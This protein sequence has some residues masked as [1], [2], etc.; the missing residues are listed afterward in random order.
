MKYKKSFKKNVVLIIL[1]L[2]ILIVGICSKLS[3]TSFSAFSVVETIWSGEVAT[4]FSGG[5]GTKDNPYQISRGEELAYFKTV[6]ESDDNSNYLDKYYV[7]TSNINL[8]N[9]Y[10]DPI[11]E[12]GQIFS[13]T[14]DGQGYTISNLKIDLVININNNLY[15]GLFTKTENATI[16]NLNISNFNIEITE[17]SSLNTGLL[18]ASATN[19]NISNIAIL[20]SSIT[21]ITQDNKDNINI[22]GLVGTI[23]NS[24][25]TNLYLNININSNSKYN[26]G[27][28]TSTSKKTSY[29]NILVNS[30]LDFYCTN[31]ITTTTIYNKENITTDFVDTLNNNLTTDFYWI[32]DN[33]DYYLY[34]EEIALYEDEINTIDVSDSI[35]LHDSGIENDIVYVNDLD[36]DYNYYM[37]LN[38]TYSSDNKL[39]TTNNKK[40]YSDNNLVNV[41]ITYNGSSILTGNTTTGT[42]STTE[43]ENKYIYYKVYP[44][45]DNGTSSMTDDYIEI[46][47]IDNPF[48]NRPTDYGF[49][50]WFTDYSGTKISIDSTIYTRYAKVP[51]TYTGSKPNDIVIEFKAR[52]TPAQ[53]EQVLENS[54]SAL[55]TA[56]N[57]FNSYGLQELKPYLEHKTITPIYGD[58]SQVDMTQ[59]YTRITV[60]YNSQYSNNPVTYDSNGNKLTGRC[61]TRN[62]CTAYQKVTKATYNA[63]T[64]YYELT[65]TGMQVL[66]TTKTFLLDYDIDITYEYLFDST[67]NMSTY[68]EQ[69]TITRNNSYAGYYNAAGEY[70]TSGTCTSNNGCTYYKLLQYYDS[71]GKEN[72]YDSTKNYYYLVTRDTNLLILNTNLSQ[73]WGTSQTKPLT[74]TGLYSGVQND[75]T[76]DV[77]NNYVR[78]SA[79]LVIENMTINAG[80]TGAETTPSNSNTS[81]KYFYGGWNNVKIGRGISRF[82]SNNSF[83]VAMG[84]VNSATGSSNNITKYRFI[85][86]SGFYS[87]LSVTGG[88]N[89]INVYINGEAIYGNDYDR[90]KKDNNNLD[91]YFCASGSWGNKVY[92]SGIT[93]IA[94]HTTVKSGKFGSARPTAIPNQNTSNYSY[95]IYVGGRQGGANY[96]AREATIEGGWVYNLIGGPLAQS[97]NAGYNDSYIYVKGGEVDVIIGGAGRTETYGNRIIQVTGGTINYSIFGG[98]NGVTSTTTSNQ[99]GTLTGTPYIYVGGNAIIGNSDYV[100]NN[101]T[102]FGFEAGSVFGIGNGQSGTS[103]IGTADNSYIIIDGSATILRNVYG[104]GN[105]GAVG[106]ESSASTFIT[107]INIYGGTIKGSVFGGGNKNGSGINSSNTSAQVTINQTSGTVEGS[108]YG[109]ANEEGTIY[110]SVLINSLGG[111]I[112]TDIYGGGYGGLTN[113]SNGTYVRDSITIKVGDTTDSILPTIEGSVYGGSAFGSVNGTTNT[114]NTSSNGI[115]ITVNEGVIKTAVF[116]GAKGNSTYTPYVMGNILVTINGG[117]IADVFGGNNAAGTP[118]GTI[119]IYLNGGV[120]GRTFGGGNQASVNT[121]NIYLEGAYSELIFG[122]SN[123]DGTVTTSNI[124]VN[125]GESATIYGGNNTDGETITSN[126]IINGGTINN[127]VYGGGNLATTTTTNILLKASIIPNVYGGGANADIKDSTNVILNGATV[128]NIY[129]GSNAGGSVTQSFITLKNGI[130]QSVYGGNNQDGTTSTTN[131]IAQGGTITNIYGGG[132]Q[133]GVNSSNIVLDNGNIG[134]VYGGSNQ[135]G[136]VPTTNIING[137]STSSS[138]K[139]KLLDMAIVTKQEWDVYPYNSM[140]R[141]TVTITNNT[142]V[143]IVKWSGTIITTDAELLY[144]WSSTEVINN[145]NVYTFNEKNIW[146]SDNVIPSGGSYTFD[147]LTGNFTNYSEFEVLG[148][149]IVG[150]DANGNEYQIYAANSLNVKN[151]YGGNNLGGSTTTPY[152]NLTKGSYENVYGGGNQAVTTGSTTVNV[153]DIVVKESLYG[154]GNQAAVLGNTIVNVSGTTSITK[155]VFGGGNHGAVGDVSSDDSTAIVNIVGSTIGGNVYGGCNTSVVYGTTQVNIGLNAVTDSSM[156]KDN[157]NISGTIF[158]GGEANE[159]GSESYDFSFIS[160]TQGIDI[161]IDGTG[162]ADNNLDFIMSGSIFGSGNASSSSGPSN[163]YIRKLGTREAPNTSISIQRADQ[164]TIDSSAIELTGTTDRTNE[165]SEIKYSLNRIK[166]LKIKNSATLL[167]RENANMLESFY[168][169]VDIDGEEVKATVTID[170]DNKTVTK[171]TDNRL[172]MLAGSILNV[173]T[174]EN[175]TSYGVVSGMTFLGMYQKYTSGGYVYGMYADDKTYGSSA[176]AGD[177]ITGGSYVLGLHSLN[178]DITVDGYYSNYIDDEYTSLTTAYVIPEPESSN[179]YMWIIGTASINYKINLTA[180][181]YS[182]LGT[183]ELSLKDF[184]SGNTTFN[185]IGFNADGLND[186]VMIKDSTE[187]PKLASTTEEANSIIGLAMKTETTEWTINA[188]TKFHTE[189][190]DYYEGNTTY[191]TD[192]QQIAPSLMFYL[193]HAKN[194][195]SNQELGTVV[196]TLQALTPKNEIE[197][198]AKLITITIDINTKYYDD[199]DAYD[200]SITYNKKYEM[201]SATNVNITNKS[202]FTAYYSLFAEIDEENENFYGKN[203]QYYHVLVSNYVLP[204]GTMITMI[205][206]GIDE[207]NPDYYYFEV[208]E[209]LYKEKQQEFA[210]NSEVTYRISDFI[211]MDSTSSNNTYLEVNNNQIYYHEDIG[212]IMEEFIFIFDFKYT[213]DVGEQKDNTI[214]FELR[215]EEDRTKIYVLSI[216]QALMTYSLYQS[217]NVV[218]SENL[219]MDSKYLYYDTTKETT[220]STQIGYNQ[221]ES[222]ES[223][224]DT[225]YESSSMGINITFY[226]TNGTLVSSSQLSST[227]IT[228]DN[229]TYYV[230][231]NGIFRIKLTDKV[232]NLTKSMQI[233]TGVSLPTGNYTMKIALFAS[234]DGLHNSS[235]K[236]ETII[237]I[238]ICV[239]GNDNLIIAN[240]EDEGKLVI[241]ETGLNMNDSKDENFNLTYS[242]VL[243]DPNIRVAVY[244]RS[245]ENATTNEYLEYNIKDLFTNTYT[246]PTGNYIKQSTYEFMVTSTPSSSIKLTYKLKDNL[247]SGTYKVVFR[248]Y[249]GNQIVDE[250]Y[251]YIIIRKKV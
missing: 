126:I 122:G 98:S 223:I 25:L 96:T 238:P 41:Q 10:F 133:A 121:N 60:R 57:S 138:S 164:V 31:E 232:S 42:V 245:T 102:L 176:T 118:N 63:N 132:N 154:G 151:V 128:I 124:V 82:S 101:E 197:Y 226:D 8:G 157:I 186:G 54:T 110:G 196:I 13:G 152:I 51:I 29:K 77:T 220:Y 178:H 173:T 249:D 211:R 53:V 250:D 78:A 37:G 218:L 200:A 136:V 116:G 213:E 66:D 16:K 33:D 22:G 222:R 26:L 187:V 210:N 97:S 36:A 119:N 182:S 20:N 61:R 241:G 148:Y 114:T 83:S 109:G 46:E 48:T 229:K 141:L 168:S 125:S 39:P 67:D 71:T 103:T 117:N 12:N 107:E 134:N 108:I 246:Y 149:D 143:E 228:I 207:K 160:V 35:T 87:S 201:P 14:F 100:T 79:D 181:K 120:I 158:G 2:S 177:V 44:V 215:T 243:E 50:G 224:I 190:K 239:V 193:Y 7:L 139:N 204:V 159:K 195:S 206:Y 147:F 137:T 72:K 40:I 123:E 216:R 153:Q 185:V 163:I 76:W 194:I 237:E 242:S 55:T 234:N 127:A 28:I 56:I 111:Q 21:T 233:T 64:T 45:N 113:T 156:T 30:N 236:G 140:G 115:T 24:T 198:E 18:I 6:I 184:S 219:E 85:V 169:L 1:F 162:Y 93:S 52:W 34:K 199:A 142:D 95:G 227:T 146:S 94:M 86:E 170:D 189:P 80:T 73:S 5:N 9:L 188:A 89:A 180:S 172:Y 175:A 166:I 65:D 247:K 112:L 161:L 212:Y 3:P 150:Y 88:N 84:G 144:N 129:G 167:L 47:L 32:K 244:K 251:K 90:V 105:Y 15:S 214:Y 171:N 106:I 70:Q 43:K 131:I 23:E 208:S 165:Y 62:G 225:N 183:Y 174:N 17:N 4:S 217:S 69:V 74:F 130:A 145:N 209:E 231:G 99:T 155:N 49:N 11:G 191:S 38:Y 240:L 205:D 230:D 235:D 92:Q 202:Q 27:S 135:K 81:T 68:F 59:Y 91:V 221:T 104:G 248:L 192:N 58:I 179:Y 203:Y 19:T 75:V